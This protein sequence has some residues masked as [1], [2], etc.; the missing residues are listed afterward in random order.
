M[1][2][3]GWDQPTIDHL[4]RCG[5][6]VLEEYPDVAIAFM[7]GSLIEGFGNSTSDLDIFLIDDEFV[8]PSGKA[9][10]QSDQGDFVVD[11]DYVDDVR[12]DTEIWRTSR[13][14]AAAEEIRSCDPLDW[15][16]VVQL[17]Q[18]PLELA[19]RIRTGVPLRGAQDFEELRLMFDY[20]RL[21]AILA[22]RFMQDYS[23]HSEDC[24]GAIHAR[25]AGAALLNSRR[26]LAAAAD[27]LCASHGHTN[28]KEKW[29]LHRMGAVS[30]QNAQRYIAAELD[31]SA[32]PY[33]LLSGARDR[34]RLAADFAAET[35]YRLGKRLWQ[36][37]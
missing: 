19:H 20:P 7:S 33:A 23:E 6:R 36:P 17:A 8:R 29:R 15:R 27:A 22:Q 32:E 10:L 13:V 18:A 11:V 26:A 24:V 35:S 5:L 1:L 16:A 21:A 37:A 25:D 12:T 28:G 2:S 31:A 4:T 34:L 3:D 14:V 9:A 30:S